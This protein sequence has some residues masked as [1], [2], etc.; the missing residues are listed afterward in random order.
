MTPPQLGG[1]PSGVA[2]M[3]NQILTTPRPG[4]FNGLPGGQGG[5]AD[6][7]PWTGANPLGGRDAGDVRLDHRRLDTPR[8]RLRQGSR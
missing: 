4:G 5:D 7:E 2:N 6:G 1:P 3:L 8:E